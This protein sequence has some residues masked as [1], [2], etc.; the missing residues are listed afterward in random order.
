MVVVVMGVTGAG[1]TTVGR[2]LAADLG[3]PFLDADDFHPP[4]NVAKMRA[5][6]PLTDDYRRPWLAALRTRIDAAAAAGESLVL[7]CSALKHA[8]QEYLEHDFPLDVKYVYLHGS[9]ELIRGRLAART[10]HFMNPA[11]LGSQLDALEPPADAAR[12]EIDAPPAAVAA[13]VRRRLGV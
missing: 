5:G 9:A 3:W 13:E 6:V 1:K 7:A 2:L 4:A 12:V 11:L 10:G 8:Y